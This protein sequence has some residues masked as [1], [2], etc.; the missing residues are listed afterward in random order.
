MIRATPFHARAATYNRGNDWVERNGFTISARYIGRDEEAIA[1]R[2]SVAI[3]DISTRWRVM[4]EGKRVVEFLRRLLTRDAAT[5]APS[6]ALKALWLSDGG[7]V[8]GAGVAARC[9]RPVATPGT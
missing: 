1:A 8:R 7:G 2:A 6:S 4:L 5:L 3:V 9:E